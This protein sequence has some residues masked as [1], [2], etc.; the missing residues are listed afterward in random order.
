ML[1][2]IASENRVET[3][4]YNLFYL[5]WR[6]EK[7]PYLYL[8]DFGFTAEKGDTYHHMFLLGYVFKPGPIYIME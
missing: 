2:D 3:K 6:P 1:L 5:V 7:R 8:I 4:F